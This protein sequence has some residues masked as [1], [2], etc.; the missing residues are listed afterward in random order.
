M[1]RPSLQQTRPGGE[2]FARVVK[3]GS[4]SEKEAA[5]FFWQMVEVVRHCHGLGVMHRDI[6]PEVSRAVQNRSQGF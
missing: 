5:H 2:L 1:G 4:F 3:K 6:K